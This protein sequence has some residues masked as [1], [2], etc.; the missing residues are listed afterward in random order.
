MNLLEHLKPL[1]YKAETMIYVDLRLIT[2]SQATEAAVVEATTKFGTLL[3][4]IISSKEE[5]LDKS[6]LVEIIDSA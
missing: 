3:C 6:K 4:D 2:M 1:N 5:V